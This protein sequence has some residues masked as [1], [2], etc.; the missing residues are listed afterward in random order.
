MSEIT[1][2]D[3]VG[4]VFSEMVRARGIADSE[5][6]RVAMIYAE[7]PIMKHFSVPRFKIPEMELTIPVLI[8][9]ARFSTV[10]SFVMPQ[11]NF[12]SYL[13]GKLDNVIKS[14]QLKD[15]NINVLLDG[16]TP[17][18]PIS[19]IRTLEPVTPILITP[20]FPTKQ[21][22]APA[23]TAAAK[24]STTS[25]SITEFYTQLK[26]NLDAS[27]PENII[28]DQWFVIFW[29]KVQE[30]QLQ[31]QYKLHYPGNDLFKQTLAEITAW[32]K[33]NTIVSQTRIENLLVNPET[34]SV[35][36]ESTEAS[37][38][39]V[40]AKIIEEG[41]FIRSVSDE[42]TGKTEFITEFE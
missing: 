23:R 34:N 15:R 14:I 28:Q 39:T 18:R 40:K 25:A 16:T 27:R 38:F 35:K 26:N 20:T 12:A 37:V 32:V 41:I 29:Q 30:N 33:Q 8:S 6:K 22:K 7:D 31:E 19:P 1:L 24:A 2:S 42:A 21:A 5:S 9:G 4:Y 13:N 3:F 11:E 17:V 36:T 10:Y